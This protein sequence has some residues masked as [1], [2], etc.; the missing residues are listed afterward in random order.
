MSITGNDFAAAMQLV[1]GL[2]VAV[3]LGRVMWS[4]SAHHPG[5]SLL[6]SAALFTWM[7]GNPSQVPRFGSD[8]APPSL[9]NMLHL[10]EPLGSQVS[11]EDMVANYQEHRARHQ[12][13][14]VLA[15]ARVRRLV[16]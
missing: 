4:F 16:E 15:Q 11:D 2:V 1:F 6:G 12:R 13:D 7:V 10:G 14:V 9:A 8:A 3:K 5:A